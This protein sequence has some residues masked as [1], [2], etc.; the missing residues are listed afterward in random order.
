VIATTGAVGIVL[1]LATG[2]S[3][4]PRRYASLTVDVDAHGDAAE[5]LRER[6]HERGDVALRRAAVL[7]ARDADDLTIAVRV[8][9]DPDEPSYTFHIDGVRAGAPVGESI[10]GECRLCTEG[11]LVAAIE[12]RLA[13]AIAAVEPTPAPATEPAPPAVVPPRADAQRRAPLGKAGIAGVTLLVGGAA[14][15]ATGMGLAVAPVRDADD[16]RFDVTTRPVG[17]ALLGTG[18]A[19]A[20]AGAVLVGLDRRTA[21]RRARMALGLRGDLVFVALRGRF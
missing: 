2:A 5:V 7:P 19:I 9:E 21:R 18:G 8:R 10:A 1:A 20:I 4:P 16:P 12:T 15:L 3:D 17:W 6:I 11:E 13:D 14:A